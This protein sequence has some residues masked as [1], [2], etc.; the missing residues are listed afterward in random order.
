MKY[1]FHREALE[2]YEE[3]IRYYHEKAG[4]GERFSATIQSSIQNIV[5]NPLAWQQLEEG[6]H[7][8]VVR[9]FPYYI[10]YTIEDR[11]IVLLAIV[12][13]K[14]RPGIWKR[15]RLSLDR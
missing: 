2:E 1:R 3:A 14:R 11:V 15:R 5:L 6:V 4:L 8:Y 10:F 12:H 13:T 7:R 9:G